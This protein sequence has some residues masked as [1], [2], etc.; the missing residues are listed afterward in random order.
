MS[1]AMSYIATLH[2]L[3]AVQKAGSDE[4]VAVN[5]AMRDMPFTD[6][7]LNNPRIQTNGTVA[8][9]IM[10]V[11]VKTPAESKY[12]ND[13]YKVLDKVPSDQLFLTAEQ[14]GCAQLQP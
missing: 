12:P 6:G 11:Q 10:L 1:H 2:Y 3:Q 8:M 13:V 4:P 7:M 9:D 14:S 5:K